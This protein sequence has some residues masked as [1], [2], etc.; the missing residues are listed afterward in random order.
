MAF[1]AGVNAGDQAAAAYRESQPRPIMVITP[2]QPT[3]FIYG[4]AFFEREE[5]SYILPHR[6]ESDRDR[7]EREARASFGA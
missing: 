4:G 6:R 1:A 5:S 3:S 7:L 2:G